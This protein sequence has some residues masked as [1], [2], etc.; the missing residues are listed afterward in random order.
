MVKQPHCPDKG[1]LIWIDFDPQS[2]KEIM[3]RRPALVLTPKAYNRISGLCL[4]CP[5]TSQLKGHDFEIPVAID[6][7]RGGIKSDQIKSF[8]WHIRKADFIAKA[9][10]KTLQAVLDNVQALLFEA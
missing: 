7:K 5:I 6:K 3:K 10:R 2:G 4:L 1:D 8:D 9:P